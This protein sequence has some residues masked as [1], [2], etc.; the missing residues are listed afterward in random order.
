M[1]GAYSV[2]ETGQTSISKW[3]SST[4]SG[5]LSRRSEITWMTTY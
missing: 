5:T 2:L 1:N 3:L 4:T